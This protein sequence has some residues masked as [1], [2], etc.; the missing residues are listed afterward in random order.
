MSRCRRFSRRDSPRS[1]GLDPVLTA[2]DRLPGIYVPAFA[3][4]PAP[5][6]TRWTRSAMSL[7]PVSQLTRP[8]LS[9]RACT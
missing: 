5:H 7:E 2:L 6:R 4:R 8:T 9:S 1:R 3:P